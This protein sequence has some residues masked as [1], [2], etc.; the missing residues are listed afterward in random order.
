MI[1]LI[2]IPGILLGIGQFITIIIRNIPQS[3]NRLLLYTYMI[4]LIFIPGILLGIG[5]F[6]TIIVRNVPQL[7]K[8]LLLYTYLIFLI[9]IPGIL[10][11]IGKFIRI[12]RN[13]PHC[14]LPVQAACSHYVGVC[15]A[16]LETR[17][18]VWCF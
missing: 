16:E 9:F 1:I 4:I 5:R 17:D 11:G 15:R 3:I 8:R 14:Y 7:I 6:I 13:V 2:F 10:L 12:I 18:I